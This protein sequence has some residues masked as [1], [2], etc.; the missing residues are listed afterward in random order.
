MMRR[1]CVW[2]VP[3]T[4]LDVKGFGATCGAHKRN[5]RD[6]HTEFQLSELK[7]KERKKIR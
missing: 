7:L 6:I 4:V 2:V 1:C 5:A 3:T